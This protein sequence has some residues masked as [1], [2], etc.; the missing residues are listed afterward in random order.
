MKGDPKVIDALNDAL[1]LELTAINQYFLQAKMC[2]NWGYRKLEK[3]HFA[4]SLGEMKHAEMLI[5]RILFLEGAPNISRYGTIRTGMDVKEQLENDLAM[6]TGAVKA[7]NEAVELC[8]K[9]KESG[10]RDLFEALLK[11]S[12]ESVDWLEIQLRLIKDVGLENYLTE[13]AGEAAK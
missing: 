10:S 1:T 5:D 6:E 11:G 4:E 9:T 3:H 2:R 8:V 7:Y 13:Q 12:E